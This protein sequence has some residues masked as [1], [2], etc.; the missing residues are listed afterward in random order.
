MAKGS[1]CCGWHFYNKELGVRCGRWGGFSTFLV[2]GVDKQL[3]IGF[4]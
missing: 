1:L 3:G 4:S 2:G